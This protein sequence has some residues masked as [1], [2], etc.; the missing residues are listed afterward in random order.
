MNIVIL[1]DLDNT[2]CKEIHFEVLHHYPEENEGSRIVVTFY[3]EKA[4]EKTIDMGWTNKT[5]FSFINLM[6]NFPSDKTNGSFNHFEKH[7]ELHWSYE[8]ETNVYMLTFEDQGTLFLLK[9]SQGELV[10]FGNKLRHVVGLAPSSSSYK[11][12]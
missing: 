10:K 11:N 8:Y 9:S 1:K 12:L 3:R 6:L 4:V 7:L 5:L 2:S